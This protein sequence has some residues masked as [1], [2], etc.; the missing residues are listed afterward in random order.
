MAGFDFAFKM[1]FLG[2]SFTCGKL[3]CSLLYSRPRTGRAGAGCGRRGRV[4]GAR[5]PR[6]G[7]ALAGGGGGRGR[8]GGRAAVSSGPRVRVSSGK[9]AHLTLPDACHTGRETALSP[10][11]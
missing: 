7:A 9:V 4:P 11:T 5:P 8:G 10:D 3:L 1:Y 6:P 2:G